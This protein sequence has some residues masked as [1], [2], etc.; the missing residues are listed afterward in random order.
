LEGILWKRMEGFD[1]IYMI[2]LNYLY[3][4]I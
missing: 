4:D 2:I 3:P 1:I